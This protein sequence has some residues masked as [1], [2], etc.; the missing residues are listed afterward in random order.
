MN[1]AGKRCHAGVIHKVRKVGK[2]MDSI[3]TGFEAGL[4][5]NCAN[6]WSYWFKKSLDQFT[7]KPRTFYM[8]HFKDDQKKREKMFF[9]TNK[10]NKT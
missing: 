9:A 7:N 2:E 4:I 3:E 10:I 1:V 5:F 8:T 6:F